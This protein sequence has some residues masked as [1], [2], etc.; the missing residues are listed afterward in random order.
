MHLKQL[1][2]WRKLLYR[3][4]IDLCLLE[5]FTRCRLWPKDSSEDS[6][7]VA[8]RHFRRQTQV[9]HWDQGKYELVFILFKCRKLSSVDLIFVSTHQA[10]LKKTVVS[11]LTQNIKSSELNLG[12]RY[13]IE[14]L[15]CNA[16][17]RKHQKNLC[18]RNV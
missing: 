3:L 10:S 2:S 11:L 5:G 14:Y 7:E 9:G 13:V 1:W 4:S 16:S 12:S 18:I 8:K 6:W 17:Y 15:S